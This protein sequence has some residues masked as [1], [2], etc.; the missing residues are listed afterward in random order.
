MQSVSKMLLV[1]GVLAALIEARTSGQGQIIDV[2]MTDGAA[3][4]MSMVHTLNAMGDWNE[5]RGSNVLDGGAPFY[6]TYKCKDD[7][8]V[9]IGAIEPQFYRKLLEKLEFLA[10]DFD[11]QMDRTQWPVLKRKLADAFLT[12]TRD[13]W[14][15]LMEGSDAC[16]APVLTMAE[17]PLHQHNVA[18]ETF[19]QVGGVT[20][21]APVPRFSRTIL[22][23][24]NPPARSAGLHSTLLNWGLEEA[25]IKQLD[26]I[27]VV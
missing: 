10:S 21:C 13:E 20:Q 27:S 15:A 7:R 9:A 17:A 12:R 14:C 2:A 3:L 25:E 5:Q 11:A 24:P 4:L 26:L 19:I 18:R 23:R 22:D 16:V 8:W 6:G 1:T